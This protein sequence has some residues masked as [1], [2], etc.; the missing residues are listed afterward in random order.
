MIYSKDS[1]SGMFEVLIF[2][3]MFSSSKTKFSSSLLFLIIVHHLSW[4]NSF[5]IKILTVKEA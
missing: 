5:M 4:M 2:L 3:I 1:L